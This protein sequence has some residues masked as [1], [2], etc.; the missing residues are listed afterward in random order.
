MI[1]INLCITILT[2]VLHIQ[3]PSLQYNESSVFTA[4]INDD[5]EIMERFFATDLLVVGAGKNK[6]R[7][8]HRVAETREFFIAHYWI[9]KNNALYFIRDDTFFLELFP[10]E[11][12]KSKDAIVYSISQDEEFF[13]WKGDSN[14]QMGILVRNILPTELKEATIY[15]SEI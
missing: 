7:C 14:P 6:F 1:S 3:N 2:F 11:Y 15:L 12:T 10:Q 4:P 5:P 8:C 13:T 9:I